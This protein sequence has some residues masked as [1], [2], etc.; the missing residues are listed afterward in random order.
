MSL[1][2]TQS[3]IYPVAIIGGGPVGIFLSKLLSSYGV[4]HCVI[5]KRINPSNHPQAHYLNARTMEI[6]QNHTPELYGSILE[7]SANAKN[8]M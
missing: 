5:E 1:K 4:K 7:K 2:S 3:S 6:L 8:W